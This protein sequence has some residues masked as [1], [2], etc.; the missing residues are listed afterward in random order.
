MAGEADRIVRDAEEAAIRALTEL[1]EEVKARTRLNLGRYPVR[2][3]DRGF[4]LQD[5][6]RVRATRHF[7]TIT[8]PGPYAARLHDD[9]QLQRPSGSH[10]KYL[11]SAAYEAAGRMPGRIA[12]EVRA[13][14]VGKSADRVHIVGGDGL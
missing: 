3:P 7:V 4:N 6:I 8:V 2:D 13:T 1:G 5:E 12:G 10:Y 11:A 9:S 14:F